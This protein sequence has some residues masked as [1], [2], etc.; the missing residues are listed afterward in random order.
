LGEERAAKIIF[1]QRSQ[2]ILDALKVDRLG[3]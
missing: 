2:D 3:V 1:G